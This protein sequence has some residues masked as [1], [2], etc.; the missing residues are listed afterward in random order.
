MSLLFNRASAVA[1]AQTNAIVSSPFSFAC[2]I[3]LNDITVTQDIM[4]LSI[5]GA[6]SQNFHRLFFDTA[7]SDRIRYRTDRTGTSV[8]ATESTTISAGGWYHVGCVEFTSSRRVFVNGGFSDAATSLAP[9][10]IDTTWL[11]GLPS[12]TSLGAGSNHID[13]YIASACWWNIDIRAAGNNPYVQ[14][15]AGAS[16]LNFYP[17]SIVTYLPLID[18]NHRDLM[19]NYDFTAIDSPTLGAHPP[20]VNIFQIKQASRFFP[21][22]VVN[23]IMSSLALLGVGT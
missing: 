3:Y 22:A 4:T 2:W 18:T 23:S 8:T 11:G 13:G 10:G 9:S 12:T 15:A 20:G 16:P 21:A 19:G 7:F 14:M 6:T 1:L 5:A 17:E